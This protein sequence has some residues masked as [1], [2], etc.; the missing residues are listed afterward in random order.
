MKKTR[1]WFNRWFSVAYHYINAIRNNEDGAQFEFY[2]THV[3]PAHMSFQAAEHGEI[4]PTLAPDE[5]VEYCLDFCRKHQ[6]D[7][8]IPRLKMFHIAKNIQRF[9]EIGTKVMVCRDIPLLESLMEKQKFY[10]SVAQTKIMEIPDYIVVNTASEFLAAYEDLVARGHG[11]CIK[12]TN[13]EGGLGF[14][15]INN[16]RDALSDLFGSINP[17]VT[18]E[19]VCRILSTSE[20]FNDLMVMELLAGDEYSIDCLASASGEL[21]AAVP[22]RKADGRL[23]IMDHVPELVEIAERVAS[24]YHIPYNYNI[25]VKYNEGV[26]KLLEINPRMSGG[27]HSTCLT[28][29]NFPYLAVKMLLGGHV[30]KQTPQLPLSTSHIEKTVIIHTIS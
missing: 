15:I 30:D 29:I 22:R 13:S 17:F 26:P 3:D 20:R 9:E 5:Y 25:Q 12:P 10:E 4:E 18:K 16:E 19:D 27:L 11:V 1:V 21:L 2:V 24:T 8:F 6:I 23:R 7:V 28:G 14:R